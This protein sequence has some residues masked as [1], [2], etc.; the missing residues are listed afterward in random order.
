MSQTSP[1]TFVGARAATAYGR[2]VKPR[3]DVNMIVMLYD[4]AIG[5]VAQ[6]RAAIR[7][8]AIEARW[9]HVRKAAAIVDG[10]QGCLDHAAGG[11]I[12]GL[13][14]RFYSYVGMRL[15]QIDLRNDPTICDELVAR[16]GEMRASWAAMAAAEPTAT[17]P[18]P[19]A[20]EA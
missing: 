7:A 15:L 16:L 10:L 20:G 2:A 12:A 4:G 8:G 19:V 11:Q 18:R 13:L 9:Q 3:A 17:A 5:Q 14:D 6:A 1:S